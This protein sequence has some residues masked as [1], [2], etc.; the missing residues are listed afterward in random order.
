MFKIETE[1]GVC[2]KKG[3]QRYDVISLTK[4]VAVLVIDLLIYFL[5]LRP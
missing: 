3:R 4:V 5:F 1:T 2:Y